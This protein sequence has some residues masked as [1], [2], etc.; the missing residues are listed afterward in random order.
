LRSRDRPVAARRRA[1]LLPWQTSPAIPPTARGNVWA[2]ANYVYSANPLA[3]VCGGKLIFKFTPTGRSAPGSPYSGGGLNEVGFG[4]T[5]DP[6]GN[7]WVGNFGFAAKR[8]SDPPPHNSVSEFTRGG[9]PMSPGATAGLPAA[10]PRV[11]LVGR[12]GPSP[13]S[14]GTSGSRTAATTP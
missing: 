11:G 1:R 13:T 7:V 5:L 3:P 4:I 12:R 2:T 9:K 10:S 14:R 8:C 6:H